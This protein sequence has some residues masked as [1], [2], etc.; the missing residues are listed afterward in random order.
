MEILCV[1][2]A[3]KP[4]VRNKTERQ[5]S[6]ER[7]TL[8]FV[9]SA[10]AGW[11]GGG[12]EGVWAR[13]RKKKNYQSQSGH[14]LVLVKIYWAGGIHSSQS[15]VTE[16][17][18]HFLGACSS[19]DIDWEKFF[20][21]QLCGFWL[22]SPS[23]FLQVEKDGRDRQDKENSWVVFVI[24]KTYELSRCTFLLLWCQ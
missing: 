16:N 12:I 11:G 6:P 4:G 3:S 19:R 22:F 7:L 21:H 10:G 9:Q 14:P 24:P 17:I 23:K 13:E 20:C 2:A 8:S 18:F 5:I 1:I 15:L